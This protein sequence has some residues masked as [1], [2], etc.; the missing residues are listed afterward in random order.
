M[1]STNQLL[2]KI[3]LILFMDSDEKIVVHLVSVWREGGSFLSVGGKEGMLF[4]TDK[5]LMF[6]RKTERM[7]KWWKSVVTRQVV[8]LIQ[9]SDVMIKHDGYDEEDLAIDLENKKK[10]SE[11]SFDNIS[12]GA[13]SIFWDFGDGTTSTLNNPSHVFSNL[14][15]H[16][17]TLS[18]TNHLTGC[19]HILEKEIKLTKSAQFFSSANSI[20]GDRQIEVKNSHE[21]EDFYKSGDT[22]QTEFITNP[23]GGI[24]DSTLMQEIEPTLKEFSKTIGKALQDYG[25]EDKDAS[26]KN[27]EK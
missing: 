22:I 21:G 2:T 5:H 17:V 19:T 27:E 16:N 25:E 11:V 4:L 15:S 1:G 12:V 7:K 20:F 18:A 9:N 10:S 14:G 13:D 23:I 8:T 3:K 26:T 24:I 6:I